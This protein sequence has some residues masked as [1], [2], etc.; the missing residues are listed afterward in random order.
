[1]ASDRCGVRSQGDV[2]V[3]Q[4]DI[5]QSALF[6]EAQRLQT[7][8][9]QPGTGQISDGAEIHVAA[10]GREAVFAGS[11][12]DRCEGSP[13]TR[14]CHVELKSG[15]IR[16][17]TFGPNTD[18]L[19]RFSPSGTEV[20]FLSDRHVAGDFQL[21][22]L[23]RQSG[24]ARAA[25]RVEGWVEYFHWAPDGKRIL[26]GVAGHGADI[27]SGQ[28]ALTTHLVADALPSWVPQVEAG[29]DANRRRHA[30]IYSLASGEVKRVGDGTLNIWEASWCG[31]DAIVAVAS[32]EA[33]EGDWYS[34]RLHRVSLESGEARE[35]LAPRDQ[36]GLPT[37][38][39]SGKR[40]A[41][42]EAVC[43]DRWIV[44]G[45]VR[46]LSLE[47]G[48][49]RTLDARGIDVSHLEWRSETVLLLAGHRDFESIVATCEVATGRLIEVW[50]S[51][52]VTTGGRFFAVSGFGKAGDC[53]LIGEDYRRSPEIAVVSRGEYKPIKS[54]DLGYG[55]AARVIAGVDKVRWH[56]PDGQEILG[57]LLRPHGSVPHPLIM[58]IHGGP[59]WHWRPMWLARSN[60]HVLMLVAH[61]YAVFMPN[62]RGSAGRGAAFARSV[63]G[64]MGGADSRDLISGIDQL[65]DS[66][67]ADPERLG[68]TGGS[69]GGFMTSWLISQ[70]SRFAA[71]VS[72]A[73]HNNHVTEHL[74]SNIP[75][76]V[77]LF[78]GGSYLDLSGN[79]YQRSPLLHADRVKTPVL[80]ICGA[81]DRCTPPA[82]ALQFHNA[83][84]ERGVESVLVIYPEEGHGIRKMPA[85]MD[86]AAR[87]VAWFEEHMPAAGRR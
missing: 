75:D 78:V 3:K 55:E 52:G 37:A 21:Y 44:A 82:E 76:F 54:L 48:A 80:H 16:V 74:L 57:W 14:I 42:V 8:A 67:V 30:W 12:L 51:D 10:S 79:Y 63:C 47:D 69:Y 33:E 53:V 35:I 27:S 71:A 31:N 62:P 7:A 29:P 2:V 20:A 13:A 59:V 70:H 84:L 58:H 39:P 46:L 34:A 32:P 73:P 4:R 6:L 28:G 85:S 22:V 36:L 83:L 72:V 60:L 56:S 66:G 38:C 68:V 61:G 77:R 86:Y 87:V 18:R 64:D 25:P 19:P 40:L 11:I 65:V 43:S 1:M 5:R 45:Q 41:V 24:A 17:I 9:H 15:L 23:D 50:S 81:L 49:T 26:L